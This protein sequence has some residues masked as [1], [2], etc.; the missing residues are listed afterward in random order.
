M[1]Y[2]SKIIFNQQIHVLR[3]ADD[4][5]DSLGVTPDSVKVDNTKRDGTGSKEQRK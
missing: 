4:D 2:K 5:F 1:E 3:V